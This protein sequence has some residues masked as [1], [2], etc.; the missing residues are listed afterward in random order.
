MLIFKFIGIYFNN[1]LSA[2]FFYCDMQSLLDLNLNTISQKDE[3]LLAKGLDDTAVPHRK[4]K[5]TKIPLEKKPKLYHNTVNHNVPL[6]KV[7]FDSQRS[8]SHLVCPAV[9]I[10]SQSPH[11]GCLSS[12]ISSSSHSSNL[13]LPIIQNAVM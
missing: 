10:S 6:E 7:L 9:L 11:L 3:Q 2:I 13:T 1:T 8:L 12:T 5:I 4:L